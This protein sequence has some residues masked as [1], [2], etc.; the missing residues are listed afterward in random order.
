M[1]SS[2]LLFVAVK[3]ASAVS[4]GKTRTSRCCGVNFHGMMSDTDPLNVTRSLR[5]DVTGCRREAGSSAEECI[6]A[7]MG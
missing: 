5:E 2:S 4:P 6:D 3:N 7:L 1:M